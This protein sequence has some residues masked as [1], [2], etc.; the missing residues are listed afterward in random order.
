MIKF[1]KNEITLMT[2]ENQFSLAVVKFSDANMKIQKFQNTQF[3]S[4]KNVRQ[5]DRNLKALY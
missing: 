4:F 5:P 1:D 2:I 3:W